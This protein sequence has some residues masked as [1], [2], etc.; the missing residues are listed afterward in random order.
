MKDQAPSI[1]MVD[2]QATVK[3][4][5]SLK[6]TAKTRHIARRWHFVRTGQQ[7]GLFNLHWLKGE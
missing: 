4:S 3:M 7:Q 6:V 2:N 5:K 1:M